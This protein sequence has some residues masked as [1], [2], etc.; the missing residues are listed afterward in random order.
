MNTK[1]KKPKPNSEVGPKRSPQSEVA[2]KDGQ[3]CLPLISAKPEAGPKRSPQPEAGAKD[4]QQCSPQASAQ[5]EDGQAPPR[6]NWPKH[7]RISG[8]EAKRRKKARQAMGK[9]PTGAAHP[10]PAPPKTKV[11]M[12]TS[13]AD[14]GSTSKR[15]QEPTAPGVKRL[16][17]STSTEGT[18]RKHK[19]SR[20]GGN[21]AAPS[22]S[23]A[24]ATLRHLKVAIIDKLNP[25]G[26]VTADRANLIK[27]SLIEELDRTI[28]SPSSSQVKAPTFKS[29]TYS[30]EIIRVVCDDDEALAWLEKAT[31]D[32][33]PWEEVSLAVV[34]Q[35]KLPKLTKASLWIP[36]DA[37]ST[38]DDPE[39]VLRR[40]A[41]QNPDMAVA[42]WC[43]FH[44]EVKK[45]PKGHL[46]VF[47][48]GDDDMVVL[49]KRAMRLSC[50]FTSLYLKTSTSKVQDTSSEPGTSDT[51][52]PTAVAETETTLVPQQGED[53][54]MM[55][56][57]LCGGS[58]E[59]TEAAP[60]ST[61]E[62]MDT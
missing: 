16:R 31:S 54:Q 21:T 6:E 40:L 29:W 41:A 20:G 61:E 57:E 13:E 62:E 52:Q 8:A 22:Q 56:D 49:R 23:F 39:R 42:R 51:R 9:A 12:P 3:Q 59:I 14:N 18:P 28:L 55:V 4:E 53:H 33:K 35:D 27:Q 60:S 45:D 48:I 43:T 47:G 7:H 36:E 34:S 46:F 50:T 32:L 10:S 30:G 2:D 1:N 17:P 26:K 11:K 37:I 15:G 25:Y 19:K 44:H 24:E 58:S 5:A 38:S